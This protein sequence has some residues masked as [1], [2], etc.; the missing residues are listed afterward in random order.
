MCIL[1]SGMPWL[2]SC[3]SE[4]LYV[5]VLIVRGCGTLKQ[6]TINGPPRADAGA[7]LDGSQVRDLLPVYSAHCIVEEACV[8]VRHSSQRQCQRQRV[9]ICFLFGVLKAF[10]IRWLRPF[11]A[12]TESS[13]A[14]A[15]P[16]TMPQPVGDKIVKR[17]GL[18][19]PA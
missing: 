5:R 14:H 18:A 1:H 9:G 7:D 11:K 8:P 13:G 2:C 15:E 17:G 4:T 6:A 3:R 19:V 16:Y 12:K 10:F